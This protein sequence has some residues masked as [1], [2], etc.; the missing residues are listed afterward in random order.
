MTSQIRTPRQP[1]SSQ[2]HRFRF[3]HYPRIFLGDHPRAVEIRMDTIERVTRTWPGS[4]HF[5][6]SS[7]GWMRY[8][9][10]V[11]GHRAAIGLTAIQ[12]KQICQQLDAAYA[13][14]LV[15]GDVHR[16]NVLVDEAGRFAHLIDWE[17]ALRQLR[18]GRAVWMCTPGW[19]DPDD[20]AC[21][22]VSVRTDLLGVWRLATGALPDFFHWTAWTDI[23][24][25]CIQSSAP[26]NELLCLLNEEGS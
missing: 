20:I 14:G 17:P 9:R 6:R 24:T 25:R 1:A 22:T 12:L 18:D 3:K 10:Y 23:K 8:S 11:Q 26:F 19:Q 7:Q 13:E 5:L 15:H 21:R 2:P 4:T 16:K